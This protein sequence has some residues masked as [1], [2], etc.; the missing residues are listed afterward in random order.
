M[1][2][3]GLC[4]E[5][6]KRLRNIA[7]D[8]TKYH[9]ADEKNRQGN[10][11]LFQGVLGGGAVKTFGVYLVFWP[12]SERKNKIWCLM[13]TAGNEGIIYQALGKL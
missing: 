13:L 1:G 5:S 7:L 2:V 6:K 9:F 4:W 11:L 12:K 3:V 8:R 10:P